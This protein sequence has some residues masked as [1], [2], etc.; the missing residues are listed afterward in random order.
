MVNS[1]RSDIPVPLTFKWQNPF[2]I[3]S[4][5][6][7]EEDQ[8]HPLLK[9]V[10]PTWTPPKG[11]VAPTNTWPWPPEPINGS[12]YFIKSFSISEFAMSKIPEK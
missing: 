8:S 12:T 4:V 3:L 1:P 11:T 7:Y 10:G 5:W 9:F 2:T 6:W